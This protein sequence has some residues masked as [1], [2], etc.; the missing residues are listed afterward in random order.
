MFFALLQTVPE[1]RAG[2]HL[3]KAEIMLGNRNSL[4]PRAFLELITFSVSNNIQDLKPT[5]QT[6]VNLL[7]KS[8]VDQVWLKALRESANPQAQAVLQ[9]FFASAVRCRDTEVVKI[10]LEAGA[11]RNQ[12]IDTSSLDLHKKFEGFIEILRNTTPRDYYAWWMMP[13]LQCALTLGDFQLASCLVSFGAAY[14]TSTSVS[15]LGRWSLGL[16]PLETA[17]V[18]RRRLMTNQYSDLERQN[19]SGKVW[20][21]LL[22][23]YTPSGDDE[24]YEALRIAD[25]LD[26]ETRRHLL[27]FL[28]QQARGGS[29][30]PEALVYALLAD[31][32]HVTEKMAGTVTLSGVEESL[33]WSPLRVICDP[34]LSLSDE[35]RLLN[36]KRMLDLGAN[37]HY[38]GFDYNLDILDALGEAARSGNTQ[39]VRLLLDHEDYFP[40]HQRGEALQEAIREGHGDT[41]NVLLD[42][43]VE[44]TDDHLSAAITQGLDSLAERILSGGMQYSTGLDCRM[45][46]N[47]PLS[48]ALLSKSIAMV[49]SILTRHLTRYDCKALET[50]V[51]TC[52]KETW[53]HSAI[54]AILERRS[55]Q[56]RSCDNESTALAWAI[57]RQDSTL[58]RL[59]VDK[60]IRLNDGR[61]YLPPI[62]TLTPE[63]VPPPNLPFH[64]IGTPKTSLVW[65]IPAGSREFMRY[66][67]DNGVVPHP[68]D[69]YLA[70]ACRRSDVIDLLVEHGASVNDTVS[71]SSLRLACR[72]G[73]LDTVGYI[74]D[75]G[76]DIN[77]TSAS[78]TPF[79]IAVENCH[80]DLIQLL[81]ARGADVN[82]PPAGRGGATALQLAAINGHLALAKMLLDLDADCNAPAS[83]D[84]GRTALEGADEQGRLEMLNLLLQAGTCTTGSGQRQYIRAVKFAMA[85]GHDA[86][87]DFLRN[88]RPWTEEDG[89]LLAD[90][91]LYEGMG[92]YGGDSWSVEMYDDIG[93]VSSM[94]GDAQTSNP[95]DTV[96]NGMFYPVETTDGKLKEETSWDPFFGADGDI[97]MYDL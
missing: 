71:K 38:M 56:H 26:D 62:E 82:A 61:G 59:L 60:G 90:E 23:S 45:R 46:N 58:T 8:A 63:P 21:F 96:G 35:R 97:A 51:R 48:A 78:R 39:I 15:S 64:L 17:A 18:G 30:R 2:D 75:R 5:D 91:D 88:R 89:R 92:P 11:N 69:L 16:G 70:I 53:V 57:C 22:L 93:D 41:A 67:L 37:S 20:E 84:D 9:A 87:A 79:Q 76:V 83:P 3:R 42:Y 74:L 14:S 73:Q 34:L 49:E 13:P 81:L 12:L 50:A 66:M 4:E 47:S 29:L 72:L 6:L 24:I 52:H 19:L 65:V 95:K 44:P 80:V 55:E 10:L 33:G 31:E 36:T 40:D 1:Q 25:P 94:D 86:A 85:N 54:Q 68:E 43:G 28:V 77:S 32:Q 7:R 27:H